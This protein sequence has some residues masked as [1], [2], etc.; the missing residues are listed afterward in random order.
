M[1]HPKQPLPS[2]LQRGG[3]RLGLVAAAALLSACL[4]SGDDAAEAPVALS[5]QVVDGPLQGAVVCLDL[6]DNGQ[7]DSGEPQSITD[8]DG[9]YRLDVAAGEAGLHAIVAMAPPGAIDKE[10][11]AAIGTALLLKA[12]PSGTPGAQSVFVS[13]LSTV[14]ADTA[15]LN[16]ISVAE[17]AASVQAQLGLAASP[18]S[19]FTASGA[20]AGL[21]QAARAVGRLMLDTARLAADASVPAAAAATL[22][23]EAV[24]RQL[25][26]LA[27]AL[28]AVPA[29]ASAAER[30]QAA[31]VAVTEALNLSPGTV[32]VVAATL[33]KPA[34]TSDAAGPFVSVRRFSY[35]DA[36][37]YSYQIFTGDSSKTDS[38]GAWVAHEPRASMVAGEAIAYSRN[39]LYWT[40]S[41]WN[42]CDNGYAVVSTV[43]ATG[44]RPQKSLYCGASRTESWPVWEDIGGQ[45]L[46]AVITRMRAFPL[47]DTVGSTTDNSGLPV[48]WGPDPALLPAD[49]VFPAGARY[50][51][52][53]ATSDLG[54]TDR[55]ELAVKP[56]VRWPDGV[57]R[58]ATTLEHYSG[59]GGDLAGAV[60]ISSSNTA[61]LDDEPPGVQTDDTLEAFKRWRIAVDVAGLK[62]RFYRCDLRKSDQV[63]INCVAMGDGTLSIA[64]QGGLR[65]LR[66][67]GGYPP[68]LKQRVSRQRFWVEH[69]GTVFRGTTDLQR[70]Y[71]DQRL[72]AVAWDAL[73]S[74]LGL[75]AHTEPQAPAEP[76]VFETLRNFSFTDARN[77]NWRRF[78]GDQRV[79][80][81]DGYYEAVEQRKTVANGLDQAFARH[82]AYWTGST[83]FDCPNDGPVVRV[84]AAAPFRSV[85]CGAYVDERV[86]DQPISLGGRL[87]S[88]VVNEIRSYASTDGAYSYAGWGPV[89]SRVPALASTRFP[90]GAELTYRGYLP[91]T[92]PEAIATDPASDRVRIAPSATS[93]LAFADWPL[94]GTLEA[95][96]AAYPGSLKGSVLNGNTT[97]FVWSTTETPAD[98]AHTNRVEIRVAFDAEGAKA[99]FTR[100]N[101]LVSN[102]Q[103]TNYSTLLDT[104][105]SV[106]TMGGVRLLKFAAMP[107]GFESSFRFARRYAE[108]DGAVWY[109][110]KDSAGTTPNWSI[111]LNGTASQALRTALGIE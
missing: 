102:G 88:E 81:A 30:S 13:P 27:T 19:D 50:S 2:R 71:H 86:G 83:W 33:A 4:G 90:A 31:A 6:N 101:R 110:F 43:A 70:S 25:P 85:Y 79:R 65:L 100:N 75:S 9:R 56:T 10:T 94:A 29:E 82:R 1:R 17:A 12:P 42:R 106:E 16:G 60:T 73:R 72:N 78:T 8:A 67:A 62:A 5:G 63:S 18:L 51:H 24:T 111:R 26:V 35:T 34:G 49:A 92:L 20:D 32:A 103:S 41:A 7:C 14:V 53:S 52:R 40:G 28:A 99:R 11:G 37:N 74:A 47:R 84:Q 64:T 66:V 95:V 61:Y 96:I 55:I 39:Q 46:R 45:T 15:A 97:L 108:R 77:Y 107:E 93:S 68:A 98:P 87:M 3:L 36:A 104:T 69:V 59:M 23:R 48:K 54:G 109:A 91:L 21:G 80:D 44:T 58:Q 105:Y 38:T 89:V 57:F 22:V 76:G